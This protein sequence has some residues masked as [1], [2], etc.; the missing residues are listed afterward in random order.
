MDH[1]GKEKIILVNLMIVKKLPKVHPKNFEFQR[2][3]GQHKCLKLFNLK[4]Y[5]HALKTILLPKNEGNF[6]RKSRGGWRPSS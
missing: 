5:A 4:N 2:L 3:G 6:D 1:V